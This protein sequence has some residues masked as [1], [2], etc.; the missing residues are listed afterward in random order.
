M[1]RVYSS[2]ATCSEGRAKAY[3]LAVHIE[4]CLGTLHE[5][6]GGVSQY[7]GF[8]PLQLVLGFAHPQ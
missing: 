3:T 7:S 8:H 4:R 6:L 5:L 2:P 1:G